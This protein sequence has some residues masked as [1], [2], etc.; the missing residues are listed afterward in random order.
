M[1]KTESLNS[2]LVNFVFKRFGKE[3]RGKKTIRHKFPLYS[4]VCACASASRFLAYFDLIQVKAV[5][6]DCYWL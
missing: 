4:C 5:P 6:V 1:I 3:A 2:V